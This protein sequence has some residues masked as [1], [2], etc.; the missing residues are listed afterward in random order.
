M[1]SVDG[2]FEQ[3]LRGRTC[4]LAAFS[5]RLALRH[6]GERLGTARVAQWRALRLERAASFPQEQLKTLCMNTRTH[7]PPLRGN[8]IAFFRVKIKQRLASNRPRPCA[9]ARRCKIRAKY[10]AK[11]CVCRDLLGCSHTQAAPAAFACS[12]A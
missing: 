11:Q 9:P 5:K 2:A 6:P 12:S 3:S 4:S 7:S 8:L 1:G 10:L